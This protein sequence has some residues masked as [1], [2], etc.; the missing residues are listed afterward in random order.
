[1]IKKILTHLDKKN[2]PRETG[3]WLVMAGRMALHHTW[4]FR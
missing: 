3:L 1:M 2:T 4:I